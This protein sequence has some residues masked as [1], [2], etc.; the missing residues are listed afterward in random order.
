MLN[1]CVIVLGRVDE[2]CA[3]HEQQNTSEVDAE[4]TDIEADRLPVDAA[5]HTDASDVL[6]QELQRAEVS[7]ELSCQCTEDKLQGKCWFI[8]RWGKHCVS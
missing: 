6:V 8:A 3:Q 7:T 4:S 2:K 5:Q 1:F